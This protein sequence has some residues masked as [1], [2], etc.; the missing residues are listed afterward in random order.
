[1]A[2][3]PAS[4]PSI[5]NPASDDTLA[6]VPHHTQHAHANDEVAAV[7]T[8]IGTG[9]STPTLGTRLAGTG[10]GTSSW[11]ASPVVD[12]RADYG[13]VGDGSTDDKAAI[14][15][16]L[17]AATGGT[18]VLS[19][20]L[21]YILDTAVTIPAGTTLDG[22]GSAT[23]KLK[24]TATFSSGAL[25][26]CGGD[27]VTIRGVTIDGNFA[28]NAFA[29][30]VMVGIDARSDC[31]LLD[32]T[33]MD[34][35]GY[36]VRVTDGL[37]PLISRNRFTDIRLASVFINAGTIASAIRPIIAD[38]TFTRVRYHGI[39]VQNADR[40]LI[41]RNTLTGNRTTGM[42]VDVSGTA[43]T[44]VSGSDFSTTRAGEYMIFNGG[45]ERFISSVTD[46]T[47]LTLSASGGSLSGVAAITGSGDLVNVRTGR[48][49]DISSNICISGA[50]I[51]V[52]VWNNDDG[53]AQRSRIAGNICVGQGGPGLSIQ[54][55]GVDSTVGATILNNIVVNSGKAGSAAADIGRAGVLVL[56]AAQ[57]TFIAGNSVSDDGEE[58]PAMTYW[59]ALSGVS[60][61]EVR[62]GHNDVF[63][64]I[65]NAGISGTGHTSAG[66]GA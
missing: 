21:T 52:V 59:L 14:Q 8:K 26:A 43:V 36:G 40:C 9:S 19:G 57:D 47:H 13:A 42:V 56:G 64:S 5:T 24:G 44:W 16:A 17:T 2:D 22:L 6:S 46:S 53:S 55:Q 28:N 32:S 30:T 31:A 37:R 54:A 25:V 27:G 23:L 49:N 1:M 18:C 15:S 33:I 29:E 35:G 41:S 48:Y 45:T 61:G 7:A 65:A 10:T 51:G 4:L 66:T 11:K 20:G 60:S 58:S 34:A 50:S 39:L 62:L 38:N 63:G 12:A 3:F